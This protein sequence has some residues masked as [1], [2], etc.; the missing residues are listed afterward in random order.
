MPRRQAR[1]L[2]DIFGPRR[3][4]AATHFTP[5]SMLHDYHTSPPPPRPAATRRSMN[6]NND[7]DAARR[8][9]HGHDD[10]AATRRGQVAARSRHPPRDVAS[11][12]AAP[13][14]DYRMPISPPLA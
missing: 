13:L 7:I 11:R 5:R 1:S 8:C 3:H 6:A 2:H 4:R 14:I 10:E 9:W 12:A